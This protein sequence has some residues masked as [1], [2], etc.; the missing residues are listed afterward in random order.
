MNSENVLLARQPIY[1]NNL[2]VVAY[3]LLF[4]PQKNDQHTE[5]QENEPDWNGDRATS[6]VIINAMAEI[7]LNAAADNKPAFINFT[8]RWLESPPPFDKKSV[9]IELLESIIPSATVI[10]AVQSLVDDGYTIALDDFEFSEAWIP[11]LELAHIIKID[12]LAYSGKKLEALIEKLAPYQI[13]LLAEKV[14]NYAVYEH[15]KSLG[16]LM[17]QGYFFC[18]P[19]IITGSTIPANKLAVMQLL[20][21]LQKPDAEVTDLENLIINDPSIS[22]KLLRIFDSAAFTLHSKVDSVRKAIVLFGLKQLRAWASVIA[23]SQLSDK[24]DQLTITTL[25][26][27]KLMEL[28]ASRLPNANPDSYFT[29]GLFSTVDAYF[30]QTK[31]VIF[32][33]LPLD[34]TV[35]NALLHFEGDMG[36]ALRNVIYQDQGQWD[37][38]DWVQLAKFE[39][40]ENYMET[41]YLD[42]LKWADEIVK[43]LS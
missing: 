39:I 33:S 38:I 20:S 1:D 3:E 35:T 19:Q 22:L 27:A 40:D 34:E 4:R 9:T 28:V 2:S 15:C 31:E 8:Q 21:E 43:A 17:F 5:N 18:R 16:F 23:L 36:F 25:T 29:A 37:E 32:N 13:T 14:E 7:G 42:A 26:R 41:A 12:V 24:P 30:D 11:L 10:D 6:Q